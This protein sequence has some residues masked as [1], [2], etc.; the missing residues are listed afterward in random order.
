[1]WQ[2]HTIRTECIKRLSKL[3]NIFPDFD[4]SAWVAKFFKLLK[5]PIARLPSESH[6]AP[7]P[8]LLLLLEL[9]E[10]PKLALLLKYATLITSPESVLCVQFAVLDGYSVV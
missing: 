2:L 8:L 5:E 10:T 9:G 1:M 4:H 6:S 7:S 3:L